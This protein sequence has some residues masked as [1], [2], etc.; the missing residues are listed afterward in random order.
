MYVSRNAKTLGLQCLQ[1]PD[2]AASSGP[3]HKAC[4]IHH[5]AD[6]FLI[7]Q[8]TVSDKRATFPIKQVVKRAQ[9]WS[10]FF[11]FG[12]PASF[13]PAVC[14]GS[15]Q[16]YRTVSTSCIG[17]PW[18]WTDLAFWMPLAVLANSTAMLF[19]ALTAVL[20]LHSNLNTVM[21]VWYAF[22]QKPLSTLSEIRR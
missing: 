4:I 21:Y 3:T 19:E 20:L 10:S 13:R 7:R 18:N 9:P 14:Q 6:E 17:S 22:A 5:R 8:H 16:K 2:I 1:I 12:C 11:L 15:T